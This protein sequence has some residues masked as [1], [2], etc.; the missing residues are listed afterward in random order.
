[1]LAYG[2]KERVNWQFVPLP[3]RKGLPMMDM[4][5]TQK[6]AALNLLKTAVSQIGYDKLRRSCRLRICCTS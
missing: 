2:D 6:A 4:T 3:T 5:E 1:M